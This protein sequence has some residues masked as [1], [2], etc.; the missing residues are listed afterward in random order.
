MATI[1]SLSVSVTANTEGF[2]GAL[3]RAQKRTQEFKANIESSAGSA[4]TFGGL[5]GT[6]AKLAEMAIE[7]LSATVAAMTRNVEQAFTRMS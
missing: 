4:M 6:G 5:V 3:T 2:A 1:G 7:K